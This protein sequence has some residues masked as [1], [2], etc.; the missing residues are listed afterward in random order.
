[1]LGNLRFQNS[2]L[3]PLWL[4]SCGLLLQAQ[5]HKVDPGKTVTLPIAGATA[6]YTLD[7]FLAEASAENGLVSVVGIHSGSTHVVV[8]TPSGVQTLEFLITVLPPIY[9]KGF[10]QPVGGLEAEQTG[11]FETRYYT[12]P[13]QVQTQFDFLKVNGENW[14]HVHVVETN[15]LGELGEGE[16]RVGLSSATYEIVTPDRD[17]TLLD[18]YLDESQ[19]TIHGSIVR[20]FHMRQGNW[21]FHGGY[22]SAAAF[23]GLFLP[24]QPELVVGGGY[25]I[26]LPGIL[27]L[28]VPSMTSIFLLRTC[29]GVREPSAM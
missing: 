7:G 1:V 18:K 9:P 15:L 4:V 25:I 3:A 14:T 28:P 16:T 22:T 5:I 23:D 19:L 26:R 17:I 27:R 20:G 13:A 24:V 10:V 8:L 12:S 29:R 2:W 6:A 11:Y 21:F